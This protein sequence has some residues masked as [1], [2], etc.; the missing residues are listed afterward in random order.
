VAL[1]GRVIASHYAGPVERRM[2]GAA[3]LRAG[4]SPE[5]EIVEELHRGDPFLMLDESLGWAWGYGGND[6]KVGYVPTEAL[7]EDGSL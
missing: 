2:V 7:A 1:A 5:S 3:A 6:R 4:P